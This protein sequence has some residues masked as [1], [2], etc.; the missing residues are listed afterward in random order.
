MRAEILSIGSELVRGQNLDTN[1]QWLSRRLVAIGID[2]GFHTTV[3]DELAANIEAFRTAVARADLVL[4]TGGLG[5][6]ADDLTREVLAKLTGAELVLDPDSLAAIEAMF[7]QRNRAMPER[8]RVQACFPSGAEP[9]PN[10]HGTAPGIWLEIGEKP[11]VCM[12]GVPAEMHAMFTEQV[13]PRLC[14]RFGAGRVIREHTIH[15][16]GAGE[17]DIEQRLGDLTRRGRQPEI[18]I[19]ASEAT[20]SIRIVA[21]APSESAANE[22]LAADAA[23]V[24]ERLGHLVFGENDESL[25]AVVGRLLDERDCTLA[26]A[27]SCTGGLVGHLLTEVSGISKHYL[28]GVVAYSNEAKQQFLGVADSLLGAHGAVSPEVAAAMASGCRERFAADLA[29][30][31][32][33][34]A[35]PTGGSFEKPVGLVYVALAHAEGVAT[36]KYNW[37]AGRSSIKLRAAKTALN[38]VRLHL[39]G[40]RR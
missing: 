13:Q 36:G 16:Y 35:G 21:T 15:C 8:N 12:P 33:G 18:G 14:A 25:A 22:A 40:V 30:G 34:I 1:S 28:G 7:R 24:R 39:L 37:P 38:L 31:I 26:T 10:H 9:I 6:T 4:V 5:P 29:L 32:T 17:S 20:I 11:I 23:V 27:E 3:G 2:V 19:T